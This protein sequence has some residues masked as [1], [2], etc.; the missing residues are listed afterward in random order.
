MNSKAINR[1]FL[2]NRVSINDGLFSYSFRIPQTDPKCGQTFKGL[3][4]RCV[5]VV[6]EKAITEEQRTHSLKQEGEVVGLPLK[7]SSYV[8]AVSAAF[9]G[10]GVQMVF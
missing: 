9:K 8:K 3:S 5:R 10:R 1:S 2:K 6:R 4:L 7:L